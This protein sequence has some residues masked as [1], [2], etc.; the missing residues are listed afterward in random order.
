MIKKLLPYLATILVAIGIFVS[1]LYSGLH[2]FDSIKSTTLL[3]DEMVKST[4]LM[5]LIFYYENH[6]AESARQYLLLQQDATILSLDGLMPYA[7]DKS[8]KTGCSILKGIAK[9]RK[10]H[11]TLYASYKY[12]QGIEDKSSSTIR[13]KINEILSKWGS[14]ESC[15]KK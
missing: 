13:H 1:G 5:S 9:H 6:D 10:E 8:Y 11:P 2:I 14:A 7:D 12:N 15:E 4:E 3:Q